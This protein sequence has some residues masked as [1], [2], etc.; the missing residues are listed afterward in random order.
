MPHLAY[1]AGGGEIK[2]L[3]AYWLEKRTANGAPLRQ[4]H[5]PFFVFFFASGFASFFASAAW[6][7][8]PS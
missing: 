8:S 6:R 5:E 4:F 2:A 1:R 3:A 7:R